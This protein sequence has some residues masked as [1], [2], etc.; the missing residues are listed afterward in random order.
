[1]KRIQYK[2]YTLEKDIPL[3]FEWCLE[4]KL[5]KSSEDDS[6]R[7]HMKS[8]FEGKKA[9]EQLTAVVAFIDK[10]PIGMIL[11]QHSDAFTTAKLM[12]VNKVVREYEWGMHHMGMVSIYVKEEYRGNGVATN[13]FL[14][15][16]NT[17]LESLKNIS[18]NPSS[19]P[20]FQAKELSEVIIKK[21]AQYSFASICHHK[22]T[23]YPS[24][25]GRITHGLIELRCKEKHPMYP[26]RKRKIFNPE[27]MKSSKIEVLENFTT[28]FVETNKNGVENK[29]KQQRNKREINPKLKL[30]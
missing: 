12:S 8:C 24:F 5:Y 3:F 4:N 28:P 7:S 17:R 29:I 11:C 14:H 1:M 16:E 22:D 13:L 27:T 19:V 26:L 20:V 21:K 15:L 30:G 10:S 18:F 9:V 25:M 6:F 2:I 23:N